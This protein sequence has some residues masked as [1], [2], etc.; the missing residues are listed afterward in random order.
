MFYPFLKKC[1]FTNQS[2]SPVNN[3]MN[4]YIKRGI[5][6]L[7]SSKW[8]PD[9]VD[10]KARTTAKEIRK[11]FSYRNKEKEKERERKK[12]WEA[13]FTQSQAPVIDPLS[14]EFMDEEDQHFQGIRPKDNT[15]NKA[16]ED[17]EVEDELEHNDKGEEEQ[18][19]KAEDESHKEPERE[20]EKEPEDEADDEAED[21]V[22]KVF[23]DEEEE[24]I[25]DE[26]EILEE[27]D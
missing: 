20:A 19:K 21:Q 11:E 10:L 8:D 12:L 6:S 25:E 17:E 13:K 15:E 24:E 5:S 7:T 27:D 2:Y 23:S 26:E 4:T 1:K 14:D 3:R 16:K 22:E 18:E 9:R